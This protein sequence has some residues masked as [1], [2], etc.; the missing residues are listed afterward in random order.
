M[1]KRQFFTKT[2]LNVKKNYY[3]KKNIGIFKRNPQKL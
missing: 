3:M 2:K 1:K